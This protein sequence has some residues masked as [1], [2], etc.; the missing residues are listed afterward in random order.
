MIFNNVDEGVQ[1][2]LV[3]QLSEEGYDG[4][5]QGADFLL[6]YIA[7]DAFN[8]ARLQEL[9]LNS[10]Y[11][12]EKMA[13]QNWN[14]VWESNFQPVI[15]EDFCTIR[16]DFHNIAITTPYEIVITPKMSFGTGHHATTQ[17]MMLAMRDMD[18]Q[19]KYVF[20]FGTGTGVL[21]ILA[22]KLGASY[23]LAIDNDEWCVENANENMV[24]NNCK[25]ITIHKAGDKGLPPIETDIIL[26]NINRH[27]LLQYMSDIYA[28]VKPGG[29]IIMSGLLSEDRP[30]IVHE[31][32]KT[33]LTFASFREL[34]N[35]I[36]IV[37]N[38][39]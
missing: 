1:E 35:W 10:T 18:M 16:A 3:A 36:A 25:N 34:N 30:I 22:E 21:A 2:I 33:G 27:I 11:T 39:I 15:V 9:A 7:E 24:R 5:E 13:K 31:A 14:E 4:F 17:L 6:A 32:E 29:S 28:N 37:F 20:D 26:A 38:K 23:V 8:E 12:L 19:G